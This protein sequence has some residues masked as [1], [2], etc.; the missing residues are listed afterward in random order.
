MPS[1]QVSS[2]FELNPGDHIETLCQLSQEKKKGLNVHHHLLVISVVSK[3]QLR[4]IHNDGTVVVEETLKMS[5]GQIVAVHDYP[6]NYTA[7]QAIQRARSQTG[8]GWN[9]LT[10]N[11]E[12]FVRWAKTGKAKSTQVLKGGAAALGGAAGGAAAGAALG[13]VVPGVGTAVGAVVG[14]IVG[15]V[16]GVLLY[17]R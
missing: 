13:S 5:P 2:L 4:V 6:C 15:G 11:C 12:H 17:T 3:E 10:D 1:R 14:G 7:D 16:S 9:L 8:R